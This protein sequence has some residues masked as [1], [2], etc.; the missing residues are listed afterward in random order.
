MFSLCSYYCKPALCGNIRFLADME[1]TLTE[2][3]WLSGSDYRLADGAVTDYLTGRDIPYFAT[4]DT[5]VAQRMRAIL[6]G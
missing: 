6:A 5:G 4:I 1:T 3:D 2:S